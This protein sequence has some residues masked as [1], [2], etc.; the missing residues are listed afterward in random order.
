MKTYRERAFPQYVSARLQRNTKRHRVEA[1]MNTM[2]REESM[3]MPVGDD[4]GTWD[5]KLHARNR[6]PNKVQRN[7][8]RVAEATQR[9]HYSASISLCK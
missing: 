1:V 2:D 5:W 7:D 3:P 9:G 4:L 8:G 6:I